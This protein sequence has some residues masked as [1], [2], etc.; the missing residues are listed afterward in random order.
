[1]AKK[2]IRLTESEL[3]KMIYD[4]IKDAIDEGIDIDVDSTPPTVAFNPNHQNYVNTNSPWNPRPFYNEVRGYKVI[5]IFERTATS[6]RQD[7][8]PLIWA[9]KGKDWEFKNP[10]YDLMSLLRRFVAVT[11]ELNETFDIIVT[12]PSKNSLNNEIFKRVLRLVPHKS[13]LVELFTK[14]E[15]NWVYEHLIDTKWL[16]DKYKDEVVVSRMKKRIYRGILEMNQKNDG[17][18]SY[19]Y[20]KPNELRDA[21]VQSMYISDEYKDNLE[22]AEMINN[23]RMLILDDTVTSG[24]TIS[25]SANALLDTFDPKD[26]TFLTLFTPLNKT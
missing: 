25:D 10:H 14:Y 15:A 20:I 7:G 22:Y 12:T 9:L 19:K 2:V 21:I 1:M 26:I 5:S 8:N 16:E 4:G 3:R 13:S 23:K 18:F 17:V 11:K 6:D 24:K